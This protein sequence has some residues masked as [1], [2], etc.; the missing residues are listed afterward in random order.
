MGISR[1]GNQYIQECQPWVLVKTVLSHV[2][3]FSL[4]KDIKLCATVQFVANNISVLL[5]QIMKPFMPGFS[6][7]VVFWVFNTNWL[8]G[9]L[10]EHS[11]MRNNS[12]NIRISSYSGTPNK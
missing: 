11:C 5:A 10:S 7:K 8:G 1:L 4:K 9:T 3:F 12:R 6:R 2:V